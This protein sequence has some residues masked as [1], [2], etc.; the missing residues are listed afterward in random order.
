MTHFFHKIEYT[1]LYFYLS[2]IDIFNFNARKLLFLIIMSKQTSLD[3]YLHKKKNNIKPND[4]F[5]PKPKHN[6][7][8]EASE[9]T[10]R[11]PDDHES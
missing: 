6:S 10:V 2:L 7:S 5:K 11:L 9:E 4:A 1:S 8:R 3:A